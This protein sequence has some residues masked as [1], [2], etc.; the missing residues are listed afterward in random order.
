MAVA[1]KFLERLITWPLSYQSLYILQSKLLIMV[2]KSESLLCTFGLCVWY[3]QGT[4]INF[5]ELWVN[6]ETAT[7]HTLRFTPRLYGSWLQWLFKAS[8][9]YQ[10]R[11]CKY[12]KQALEILTSAIEN[13][14]ARKQA[15]ID[16]RP[17]VTYPDGLPFVN[18]V[19]ISP[20]ELRII[21]W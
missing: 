16:K 10:Q 12:K 15:R 20:I 21:R 5:R 7:G 11:I 19:R 18:D 8:Q 4:L 9:T 3:W 1:G 6:L 2:K 17:V 14:M 13:Y